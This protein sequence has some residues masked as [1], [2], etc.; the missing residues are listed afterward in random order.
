M[1]YSTILDDIGPSLNESLIN[2]EQNEGNS[3]LESKKRSKTEF[4]KSLTLVKKK[5]DVEEDFVA[6]TVLCYLDK[7]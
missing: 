2:N 5:L 3:D 6:M 4:K 1:S 7:N